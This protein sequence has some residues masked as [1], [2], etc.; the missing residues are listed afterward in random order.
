MDQADTARNIL[1]VGRRHLE[2]VAAV[3]RR[4]LGVVGHN[5]PSYEEAGV[6]LR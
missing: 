2:E 6:H 5:G 4:V 3:G 1:E